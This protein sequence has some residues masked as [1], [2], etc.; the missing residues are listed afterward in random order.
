MS[1]EEAETP[2]KANIISTKNINLMRRNTVNQANEAGDAGK[3]AVAEDVHMVDVQPQVE[4]GPSSQVPTEVEVPPPVQQDEFQSFRD[5]D[6]SA[7][8]SKQQDGVTARDQSS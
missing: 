4:V 2:G 8:N 1:R 3:D 5:K 6:P 7:E